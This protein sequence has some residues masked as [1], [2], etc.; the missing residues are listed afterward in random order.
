MAQNVPADGAL[1]DG[2]A[3][4]MRDIVIPF[5]VTLNT[6]LQA[7][8]IHLYFGQRLYKVSLVYLLP[9][10]TVTVT[11]FCGVFFELPCRF[12]V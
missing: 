12:L 10:Q 7:I 4:Y 11:D 5:I 9:G 1:Y 6:A 3:I 8:T 2:S